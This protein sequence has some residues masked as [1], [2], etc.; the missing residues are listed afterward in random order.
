MAQF[1][2]RTPIATNCAGVRQTV[3]WGDEWRSP[4][5]VGLRPWIPE[6]KNAGMHHDFQQDQVGGVLSAAA[7]GG[8]RRAGDSREAEYTVGL[9]SPR[10]L[11]PLAI[12]NGCK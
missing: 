7:S 3:D 10:T 1:W 9:I 8:A 2:R 5:G 6:I 12:F 11:L 4:L